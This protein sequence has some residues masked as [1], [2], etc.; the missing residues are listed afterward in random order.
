MFHGWIA[1]PTTVVGVMVEGAV[2]A[3]DGKSIYAR[4]NCMRKAE[5]LVVLHDSIIVIVPLM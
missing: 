3:V 5:A 4:R 2:L 1:G